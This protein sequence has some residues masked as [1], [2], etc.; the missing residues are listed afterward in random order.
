MAK[1]PKITTNEQ[2]VLSLVSEDELKSELGEAYASEV[3]QN[4]AVVWAKFILT[5]DKPNGNGQRVPAEEF[6][7]LINSGLY[8]PIK[9]SQGEISEGH[10]GAEPLGTIAHM[11]VDGDRVLA[12]AALWSAERPSDVEYIK[13]LVNDGKDVNISWEILFGDYTLSESGIMELRD[14]ILKAAT[15]VGNPA[16]RG[17]TPILAVAAKRWSKAYIESLPNDNFLLIDIN[18]NRHFPYKDEAGIVDP[19]RFQQI[20]DEVSASEMDEETKNAVRQQ[21]RSLKELSDN[22]E[23]LRTLSVSQIVFNV[24]EGATTEDNNVEELETLKNE[25]QTLKD[26]LAS[27]ETELTG[28]TEELE[29]LR[30]AK[31]EF[32]AVSEELNTLRS[33]KAEYDAKQEQASRLQS[34][35]A[36]FEEAGINKPE[37]YFLTNSEHLLGL[38]EAGLGFLIQELV[39]FAQ[40]SA[41]NNGTSNGTSASITI[42]NITS[43]SSNKK[44]ITELAKALRE[45]RK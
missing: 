11:K 42:P 29:A 16:Y 25:V 15:I 9:M 17:R 8:M 35:K 27:K 30:A 36:K 28:A 31:A 14:I 7:N 2:N 33:F 24:E 45:A 37:D 34:I 23:D 18:G 6:K 13:S 1:K 20:L 38:D 12:L 40:T 44:D 21:V 32:E 19:S 3:M 4:P 39:S 26:A 43:T 5:D 10:D 41:S 22:G